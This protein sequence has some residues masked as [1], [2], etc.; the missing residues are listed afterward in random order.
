M[1]RQFRLIAAIGPAILL[2]LFIFISLQIPAKANSTTNTIKVPNDYSTIQAAID[3][4][5]EGDL[6]LVAS[7]IFTENLSIGKGI[8]LSGG[9]DP[10][11]QFRL[12]GKSIIDGD[13]LGRVISITCAYSDTQVTIDGF[14]IQ[15]GDATGMG[16]PILFLEDEFG[17]PE[18]SSAKPEGE[19]DSNSFYPSAELAALKTALIDLHERDRFP[20]IEFAYLSLLNRIDWY[21]TLAQDAYDRYDAPTP[22]PRDKL[23]DGMGSGGGIYSFNASPHLLNNTIQDN[24]ANSNGEGYGGGVFISQSSSGGVLLSNNKINNNIASLGYEGRGGGI[25]LDQAPGA[26]IEDNKIMDNSASLDGDYGVGGGFLINQS[27]DVSIHSNWVERNLAHNSWG[28]PGQGGGGVGGGGMLRQSENARIS[29]NFFNRNLAA[30]HCGSHSGGMYAFGS[31]NPE[32]SGNTFAG[33]LGVIFQIY[34]DEFSG[35]MGLDTIYGATV[36]DNLFF[37]NTASLKSI[38]TG[39]QLAYGGAIFAYMLEDSEINHN[40]FQSNIT[41]LTKVGYGGGIFL[42]GTENI[43]LQVNKVQRNA[44]SLFDTGE[45]NGGG[46]C[47]RN[48]NGT[49]FTGNLFE[50]NWAS[51][52][53]EG[54]GGAIKVERYG[55]QTFDTTFDSNL[56]F[57]NSAS[58][59]PEAD[60]SGGAVEVLS[61]GFEFINNVVADNQA[62]KAG[63]LSLVAT[64]GGQLINNTFSANSDSAIQ[65]FQDNA[66]PITLTNNIIVNQSTGVEVQSGST[67]EISYTLWDGNTHDFTGAG[68][69]HHSHPVYAA[70]GFVDPGANNFHLTGWSGALDSGDPAGVPPAPDQDA[71]GLSRPQGMAVD[72]GAYELKMWKTYYPLIFNQNPQVGWIV[73]NS[74]GDGYGV[75]LHTSNGGA[76]WERQGK[77]NEIPD[78]WLSSVNA[79]DAQNAWVVGGWVDSGVILRTRDGGVTWQQQTIPIDAQGLELDCVSALNGDVAWISGEQGLILHT[80]DGGITWKREGQATIPQVQMQGVWASDAQ[81]VWAIGMDTTGED[82]VIFRTK[83]GGETWVQVPYSLDRLPHNLGLIMVQ[84]VDADT[85]WVVGP[86]QISF[87]DDGGLSWQDQWFTQIANEHVNGVFPVDRENV[88]I[89]V[90]EGGIYFSDDGGFNF[91]DH[92]QS[93]PA[94]GHVLRIYALN[95]DYAWAVT[96]MAYPPFT[97][98]VLATVDGGQ[99]WTIQATPVDTRWTGV[100]FAH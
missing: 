21:S 52:E 54:Y 47:L 9:W 51:A 30:I 19:L 31:D 44:A 12:P 5:G 95:L 10:T 98:K 94:V 6:I 53:I 80:T 86:A 87:T 27:A 58:A 100:S 63:G 72:L 96:T 29:E 50:A 79:I 56:F 39:I 91:A 37:A 83:D 82:T 60:S 34:T 89:A 35:A 49:H 68:T 11:F 65:V 88:W 22:A 23:E 14:T 66:T 38:E 78:V 33:N 13:H 97:G 59:N 46:V 4:A 18:L 73:G 77:I 81:H 16:A 71:D 41:S 64:E 67:A 25:Y 42:A 93:V 1:V 45:G 24:L 61:D 15:S 85:L 99:N 69:I 70:P 28:C 26:V 3:A 17:S 20:G 48:T 75:I 74:V 8:S 40:K 36:E 76:T 84:G 92:N 7:G 55:P 2:T 57:N 62:K 90:D 43:Q 32:I